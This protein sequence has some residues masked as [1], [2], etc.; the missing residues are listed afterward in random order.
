MRLRLVQLSAF[1]LGVVLVV[2]TADAQSKSKKKKASKPAAAMVHKNMDADVPAIGGTG[3]PV[4]YQG[5][6][7]RPTQMLNTAKYAT[8]GTGWDI[9]TGPG[10]IL[11][12]PKDTASGNYTVST[13]IDQLASPA[14][15]ESYGLFIGGSDL[16]GPNQTYLYF[17][18]RGTG[19]IFAQ[20]REGDKLTGRVAWQKGYG[21]PVAPVADIAGKASYKLA[22]QVTADSVRF[23]VNGHQTAAL[24]RGDLPVRGHYGLRINHNLRVHATP[25]TLT[26]R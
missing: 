7:D 16:A 15:P 6:T 21:V 17:L 2:G 23:F 11:W 14:H 5:R 8:V 25:V 3:V 12:N 1:L 13:T 26:R 24:P 20:T 22:L 9:T 18:V 19:E 4:G 10:H